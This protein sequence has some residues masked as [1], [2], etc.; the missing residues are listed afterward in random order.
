[1]A[2][3]LGRGLP[4]HGGFQLDAQR[5]AHVLRGIGTVTLTTPPDLRWF[6][7]ATYVDAKGEARPCFDMTKDG[8]TLLVMDYTGAKAMQVSKSLRSPIDCT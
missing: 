3:C 6:F 5:H 1:M 8:F 2:G 4:S 7:A